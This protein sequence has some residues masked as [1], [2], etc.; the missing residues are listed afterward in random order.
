MIKNTHAW[1]LHLGEFIVHDREYKRFMVII[2]GVQEG[3]IEIW[4]T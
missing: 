3:N 4:I 1:S 2:D